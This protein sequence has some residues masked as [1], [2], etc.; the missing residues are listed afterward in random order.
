MDWKRI[1]TFVVLCIGT[2]LLMMKMSGGGLE[3]AFMT[4]IALTVGFVYGTFQ[5]VRAYRKQVRDAIN[6]LK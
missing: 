6:L 1:F 2:S 3:I 5:T 4:T